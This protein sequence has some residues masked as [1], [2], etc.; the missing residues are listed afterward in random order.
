MLRNHTR[1][2]TPVKRPMLYLRYKQVLRLN[3]IPLLPVLWFGN[4]SAVLVEITSL[5]QTALVA[6]RLSQSTVTWVTKMVLASQLL[7]TTVKAEHWW[8]DMM[9]MVTIPATFTTQEQVYL[10]WPVLLMSLYTV[11]SS[12]N[13]SALTPS[14]GFPIVPMPGGC[15]VILLRCGTGVEPRLIVESAHAEWPTRAQI[16]VERATVRRMTVY[17]ARTAVFS[18]I[19]QHFQSKSSG[20]EIQEQTRGATTHWENLSALE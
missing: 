19:S 13:M 4:T 6:W 3:S 7:V 9:V 20:L 10:S 15:H 18:L 5:I 17:G 14:Y 8:M 16:P 2:L 11:N 12:L 1:D